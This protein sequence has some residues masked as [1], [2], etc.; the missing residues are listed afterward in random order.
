MFSSSTGSVWN[1]D[2]ILSLFS[3]KH[4]HLRWYWN[5]SLCYTIPSMDAQIDCWD[6]VTLARIFPSFWIRGSGFGAMTNFFF[7]ILVGTFTV[8]L[9]VNFELNE[10][11]TRL[12]PETDVV[13]LSIWTGFSTFSDWSPIVEGDLTSLGASMLN[14]TFDLSGFL[15]R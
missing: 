3:I 15:R 7:N 1:R 11:F 5:R 6:K 12:S 8:W 14:F 9:L 4:C 2:S 13:S 10:S